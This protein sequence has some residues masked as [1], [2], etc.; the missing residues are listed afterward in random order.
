MVGTVISKKY[1][2]YSVLSDGVIYNTLIS[3]ILKFRGR[4]YVGDEVIFL[5]PIILLKALFLDIHF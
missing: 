4:V 5:T 2:T 3:G 1:S